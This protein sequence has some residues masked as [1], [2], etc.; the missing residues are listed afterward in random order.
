MVSMSASASFGLPVRAHASATIAAACGVKAVPGE[1]FDGVVLTT[2]LRE[3]AERRVAERPSP[4]DLGE[5]GQARVSRTHGEQHVVLGDTGLHEEHTAGAAC[6]DATDGPGEQ[7][8]RLLGRLN[9]HA[10]FADLYGLAV[11]VKFNHGARPSL[12]LKSPCNVCV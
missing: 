5:P 11:D 7:R 12:C 9:D 6:P 2:D 3:T 8:A 10:A 4:R 1:P